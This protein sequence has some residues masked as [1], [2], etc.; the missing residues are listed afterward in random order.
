MRWHLLILSILAWILPSLRT[1]YGRR[2]DVKENF[3]RHSGRPCSGKAMG[4]WLS[5]RAWERVEIWRLRAAWKKK[6]CRVEVTEMFL[7]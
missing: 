1:C 5:S 6:C 2:S 7:Q 4:R 3:L